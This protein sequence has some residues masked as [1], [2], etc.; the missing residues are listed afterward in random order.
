MD[1]VGNIY[2][3]DFANHRIRMIDTEDVVT[4]FAGTGDPNYN[5]DNLLATEANIG[6]PT[7]VAVDHFGNVYISDQVNNR[8]RIVIPEGTIHTVAGTGER[9]YTGDGGLAHAALIQIPDILCT[10][11]E[12]D[13]YFPDHQNFVV[14]KLTRSGSRQ[15]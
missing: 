7:G 9:G 6:E 10:D 12:G 8:I 2:I 14:R 3:A 15:P 11:P 13:V 4:T 1:E 5:G